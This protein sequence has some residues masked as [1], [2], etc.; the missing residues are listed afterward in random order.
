MP[1]TRIS[2]ILFDLG[3]V[4]VSVD[5]SRIFATLAERC[6]QNPS[7]IERTLLGDS[8]WW[9]HFSMTHF[10]NESV[11]AW[12]NERLM[13]E[14]PSMAIID[15]FNA[16]LGPAIHTTCDLLP[17]LR[18]QVVLGC[19]SNTN[20]IHWEQLHQQYDFMDQFAYR[21]ASQEMGVAKPSPA[22]YQQAAQALDMSP[23][24]ILFFDDRAENIA[25]AA[26]LGWQARQYTTHEQL[27][28]DLEDMGFT[29]EGDGTRIGGE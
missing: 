22:I 13:T 23:S 11:A 18:Q 28:A 3:N 27:V 25:A 10:S 17:S 29:V 5:A 14:L 16:E 2:C 9:H 6:G 19:L 7:K 8:A 12:V 21:F 1:S 20:S 15:A 24:E 26:D 4:V